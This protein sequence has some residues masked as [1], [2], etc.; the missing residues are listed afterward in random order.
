MA[1]LSESSDQEIIDELL[2]RE[3]FDGAVVVADLGEG[4]ERDQATAEF[5]TGIVGHLRQADILH[6]ARERIERGAA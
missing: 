2:S 3:T 4:A 6:V 1:E 5:S